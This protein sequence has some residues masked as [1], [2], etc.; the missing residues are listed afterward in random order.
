MNFYKKKILNVV[1]S[2]TDSDFATLNRMIEDKA[3]RREDGQPVEDLGKLQNKIGLLQ[4]NKDDLEGK[5]KR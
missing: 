1:R 3:E 2:L 4:M 5:P